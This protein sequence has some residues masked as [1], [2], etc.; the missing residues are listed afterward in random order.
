MEHINN[1]RTVASPTIRPRIL[2][3][4]IPALPTL[5]EGGIITRPTLAVLGE[6]APE[7][8][9]P[10]RGSALDVLAERITDAVAKRPTYTIY[11][12]Y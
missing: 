6:R 3:G 1:F 12:Q 4:D 2:K 5:A 9:L 8:V 11:A 7:A 10:L